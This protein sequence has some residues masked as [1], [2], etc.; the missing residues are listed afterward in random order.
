MNRMQF[1]RMTSDTS[2]GAQ[3]EVAVEPWF[4]VRCGACR[5]NSSSNSIVNATST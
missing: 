5:S 3:R 2:Q 4:A 1:D